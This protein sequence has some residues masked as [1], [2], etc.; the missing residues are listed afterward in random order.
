MSS[1]FT[2]RS[3]QAALDRHR[4][5][6]GNR[7]QTTGF[8]LIESVAAL[9]I[10]SIALLALLQLQLVSIRTADK[11]QV[12]TQAVLLAQEKIAETLSNGYPQTG[13]KSGTVEADGTQ[14]T[15]RI[16]VT[17]DRVSLSSQLNSTSNRLRKVSV[18]VTWQTGPG[19]KRVYL[20]TYVAEN[21]IR[22]A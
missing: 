4:L 21:R 17:D 19:E 11:A 13:M 1:Q 18:D 7:Q 2:V 20:T 22:E 5:P 16:D 3:S 9:A 15:W 8:T 10:A 6:T 14:F 12:V